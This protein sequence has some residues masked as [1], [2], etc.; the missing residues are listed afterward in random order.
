MEESCR[1]VGVTLRG[2]DKKRAS[3]FITLN[4]MR[5]SDNRTQNMSMPKCLYAYICMHVSKYMCVGVYI[6]TCLHVCV[7]AVNQA[8]RGQIA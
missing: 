8:G 5:G 4:V 2:Q 6:C 7:C 1:T 3:G